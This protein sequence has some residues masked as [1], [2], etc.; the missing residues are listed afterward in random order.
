MC[1]I[2]QEEKVCMCMSCVCVCVC[3]RGGWG[4]KLGSGLVVSKWV[5]LA[6]RDGERERL[7]DDG[8]RAEAYKREG[9]LT[10]RIF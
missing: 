4:I 2:V 10:D 9:L 5:E 8:C 3:V 1:V 7:I 6:E